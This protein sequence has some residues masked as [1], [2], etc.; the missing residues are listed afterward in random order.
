M[1][2]LTYFEIKSDQPRINALNEMHL[3]P[4]DD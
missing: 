2:I 4:D 3:C 1:C